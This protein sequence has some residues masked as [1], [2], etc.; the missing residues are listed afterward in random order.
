[1]KEGNVAI[2][3]GAGLSVPSGVVNWKELLRKPA[4]SL[5]LDIE[6]EVDLVSLAQYFYNDTNTKTPLSEIINSHFSETGKVNRNHEIIAN[7]PIKTY[8]TTNYDKLI[9]QALV[10]AGKNPDVKK[11]VNDLS[12]IKSKRDAVV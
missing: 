10:E 7:L 6:K 8:W 5:G 2:F 4:S 1:L 11:R 9:E 12:R 3:A